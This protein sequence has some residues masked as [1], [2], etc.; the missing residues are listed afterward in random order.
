MD[1]D[2]DSSH[3]NSSIQMFLPGTTC[4]SCV[5]ETDERRG[6]EKKQE[7][8]QRRKGRMW[9]GGRESKRETRCVF[10]LDLNRVERKGVGVRAERWREF[11]E[12]LWNQTIHSWAAACRK[13]AVQHGMR[14]ITNQQT[15][16]IILI[17][18]MV[19]AVGTERG[20]REWATLL[21]FVR[22]I[23]SRIHGLCHFR[24]CRMVV[25]FSY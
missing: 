6:L 2:T 17:A 18:T 22:L 23:D 24:Q 12:V 15:T 25:V 7:G 4:C 10:C 3:T 8:E 21:T 1:K 19:P 13:E 14:V 16:F 11:G 5:G 20:N 9:E